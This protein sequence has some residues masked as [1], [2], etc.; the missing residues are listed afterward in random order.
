MDRRLRKLFGMFFRRYPWL[1]HFQYET[2]RFSDVLKVFKLMITG[3]PLNDGLK[4]K[5]YEE[6]F[7]KTIQPGGHAVSFGA[8]RMALY[9][10]LDACGIGEGDEVIL[11]AF[12]CEVV[13]NALMYKGIKPMY[14]D[15][16]L[17]DLNPDLNSI[18]ACITGKTRAIIAQHNFGIPCDMDKINYGQTT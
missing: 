15:I 4:I 12:T 6:L 17:H 13:V 10:I 1:V 9:A 5:E 3:G 18:E 14:A 7:E 8:G 16:R 11:P 2:L